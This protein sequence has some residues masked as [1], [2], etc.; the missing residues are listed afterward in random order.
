M[1]IK[2]FLKKSKI[3]HWIYKF[4]KIYKNKKPNYHYGE[5]GEDIFINR[6]FKN[7]DKGYY[8]DI[9]AYHTFKGSL[10]YLLHKKGWNG[11]NID[12]SQESISLFKIARP[13]DININC[14]ISDIDGE[15]YYFQNSEI[16]QQN[17]LIKSNDNQKKI[18]VESSTLNKLLKKENIIKFDYLNIDTEGNEL[19]ILKTINFLE[20]SPLIISIESN[21]F[22]LE[23]SNK[24]KI[25]DLMKENNYGLI[26]IIGVTMFF[27]NKRNISNFLNIIS[28]N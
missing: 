11:M 19:E 17:S 6:V 15:T 8:V 10:T 21:S 3:L 25:I 16:N 26:N 1:K 14:A 2:E 22:D 27:T 24:R 5:F 12:I 4:Q 20:I 9:G 13:K 23:E 7:Y 18:K 28:I